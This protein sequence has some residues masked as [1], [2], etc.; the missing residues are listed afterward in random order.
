MGETLAHLG[1]QV[2]GFLPV[3]LAEYLKILLELTSGF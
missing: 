2:F 1:V 3:H